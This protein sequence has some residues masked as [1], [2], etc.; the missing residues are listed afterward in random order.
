MCHVEGP[1]GALRLQ[2]LGFSSSPIAYCL[3]EEETL[4]VFLID[5]LVKVLQVTGAAR[6]AFAFL[7]LDLGHAPPRRNP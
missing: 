5:V 3:F 7:E 4:A 2:A 1:R 6:P